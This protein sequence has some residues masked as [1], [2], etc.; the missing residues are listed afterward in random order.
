[1]F[2]A[3]VRRGVLRFAEKNLCVPGRPGKPRQKAAPF[4][5]AYRSEANGFCRQI[6]SKNTGVSTTKSSVVM[7]NIVTIGNLS[8][9][10]VEEYVTLG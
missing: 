3:P 8:F 4:D 5:R 7:S 2:N 10:L 9:R 6:A 1:M